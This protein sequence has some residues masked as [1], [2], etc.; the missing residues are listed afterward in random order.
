MKILFLSAQLFVQNSGG[1]HLALAHYNSICDIVGKDNVDIVAYTWGYDFSEDDLAAIIGKANHRI[2]K[3]YDNVVQRVGNILSG[4]VHLSNKRLDLSILEMIRENNYDLIF[5]DDNTFGMLL[6][7]IRKEFPA[8]RIIAFFHGVHRNSSVQQLKKS[9]KYWLKLPEYL[10]LMKSERISTEVA[11][12]LVS[13]NARDDEEIT[14]YYKRKSDM[15]IPIYLE[16]LPYVPKTVPDSDGIELLFVG[17]YFWPNVL[18]VSWFVKNVMP[19]LDEK[20][21]LTIVGNKMDRLR[22]MDEFKNSRVKV[23]GRVEDLGP[24]YQ[25]AHMVVGPIFD[26]D[27]M[28]TKTAEALLYG[29]HYLGTAEALLGYEDLLCNECN[30]V[31]DFL[32][33]INKAAQGTEFYFEKYRELYLEKYSAQSAQAAFMKLVKGI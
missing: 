20:F 9:L 29:K 11:D 14:K 15:I 18:G 32:N 16:D 26:G 30:T 25:N 3:G 4:R 17:G 1:G 31:D 13:L 19:K 24:Y 6:K 7:S 5:A 12:T 8:L 27:G 21:R 10:N 23:H 22:E 28:K 33:A 2:I